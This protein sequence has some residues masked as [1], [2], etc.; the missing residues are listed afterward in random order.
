M[1]RTLVGCALLSLA[2]AWLLPV[3]A[4]PPAKVAVVASAEDLKAEAAA[5]IAGLEESLATSQSYSEDE[6]AIA[7]QAGVLACMAQAIAEHPDKAKVGV[8]ATALRD[9][10][11][12]LRDA[13]SYETAKAS[14]TAA[15]TAL[16][17][18]GS[19]D[20]TVEFDWLELIDFHSL[21]EEVNAR[22][23]QLRR[24]IRRPTDPQTDSLHATTMAVLALIT[25]K[26]TADIENKA[27][28]EKWENY[29]AEFQASMTE[30]AAA[31]KKKDQ[32]AS[33]ELFKRSSASCAECHKTFRV[34]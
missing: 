19:P 17:G 23:S 8:S 22:N 7:R 5:K 34:D 30:L 33:M 21:M 26:N 32:A 16:A 2:A 31:L 15:K 28:I 20:G 4:G 11:I 6:S 24:V 29:S 14:F 12:A 27:E 1:R 3:Y 10:A 9:A 25:H 18:N 13:D